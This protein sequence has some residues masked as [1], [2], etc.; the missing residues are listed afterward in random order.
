MHSLYILVFLYLC[1]SPCIS[2]TAP[3][4]TG[5]TPPAS[6]RISSSDAPAKGSR[7]PAWGSG[8]PVGNTTQRPRDKSEAHVTLARMATRRPQSRSSGLSCVYGPTSA[9]LRDRSGSQGRWERGPRQ[10]GSNSALPSPTEPYRW[11]ELARTGSFTGELA[12]GVLITAHRKWAQTGVR[13]APAVSELPSGQR[14]HGARG[15]GAVRPG[16]VGHPAAR[17]QRSGLS[18][19]ALRLPL[20]QDGL[21]PPA[22]PPVG[23]HGLPAGGR[24]GSGAAGN[25]RP[26]GSSR[27]G[28]GRGSPDPDPSE[29]APVVPTLREPRPL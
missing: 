2:P 1:T 21:L 24:A 5:Q 15:G 3:L 11:G 28:G 23:S 18:A 13:A 9:P 26:A 6:A 10:V 19:C 22:A 29:R 14:R 7:R 27:W 16:P 8:H 17:G 20:P 4:L 12:A 25:A